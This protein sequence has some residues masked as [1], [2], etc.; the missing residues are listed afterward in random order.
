MDRPTTLST[1]TSSIS[2]FSRSPIKPCCIKFKLCILFRYACVKLCVSVAQKSEFHLC[3]R[4]LYITTSLHTYSMQY[5]SH[6]VPLLVALSTFIFIFLVH[7]KKDRV[8]VIL[9]WL[10]IAFLFFYLAFM[11]GHCLSKNAFT[12][13]LHYG[14]FCNNCTP[15]RWMLICLEIY[16]NY[17]PLFYLEK[18]KLFSNMILTHNHEWHITQSNWN[19]YLVYGKSKEQHHSVTCSVMQNNVMHCFMVQAFQDPPLCSSPAFTSRSSL[20]LFCAILLWHPYMYTVQCL[21]YFVMLLE[22]YLFTV[23]TLH[24]LIYQVQSVVVLL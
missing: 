3:L 19:N 13:L 16:E 21:Y 2:Q 10:Y 11:P 20:F 15:K 8:S 18:K 9:L 4:R 1:D 5:P 23:W 14:G 24:R 12:V 22:M 7:S 6:S 17:I